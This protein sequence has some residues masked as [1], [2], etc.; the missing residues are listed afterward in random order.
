MAASVRNPKTPQANTASRPPQRPPPFQRASK[1][2]LALSDGPQEGLF[3]PIGF[4]TK[5]TEQVLFN[6]YTRSMC[7]IKLIPNQYSFG[8]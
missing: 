5:P 6:I 7:S 2:S 4:I 8:S 3:R 1:E